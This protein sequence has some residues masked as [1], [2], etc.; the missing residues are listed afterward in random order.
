MSLNAAMNAVIA[1]LENRPAVAKEIFRQPG[2]DVDIST[3]TARLNSAIDRRLANE[4]RHALMA[5]LSIQ[6][7]GL[8]GSNRDSFY[9]GVRAV[10]E[11]FEKLASTLEGE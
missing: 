1:L 9:A 6:P 3:L 2:S 10:E 7:E 5:T 4:L 8:N 11:K